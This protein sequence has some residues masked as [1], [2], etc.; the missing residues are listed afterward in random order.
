VALDLTPTI[1]T[2]YTLDGETWSQDKTIS[3]GTIGNRLKRLV[4][5][6]QGAMRNWRVQRFQG[7]SQAHISIARLEGRLEPLV[8]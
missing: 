6:R 3:V 2:S 4:W 7:D 1:R 5:Y 8:F